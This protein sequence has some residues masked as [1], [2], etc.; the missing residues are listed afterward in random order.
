MASYLI[1]GGAGFI[2]SHLAELLLAH[3]DAV[4]LL[5]NMSTGQAANLQSGAELIRGDI[6][7]A[8]AVAQA[9]SRVDGV[10]HLAA[11]SSVHAYL[12]HWAASSSVNACG[13][14][15][16]FEAAARGGVP[17]VYASSA[18]VY[19][20]PAELPLR[21][22]APLRPISGY[23]TDKLGNELHASAMAEA[24]GLAAVGLR[25]F[26]V[27][28]PRQS[29][30]SAYSGVISIFMDRWR[31]RRSLTVFGDG[32]QT[33][34]FVFV[35][36]VAQALAAAM[37]RAQGGVGGVF[38]VCSGRSTSILDLVAALSQVVGGPLDFEFA[39]PRAGEISASLG[40][41]E[42]AARE[43][44][45]R[46]RTDFVAGLAETLAWAQLPP[47]APHIDAPTLARQEK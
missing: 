32:S 31:S 41:P 40:A 3:G 20:N 1:T 42:A 46:A 14:Y 45:F 19:G 12:G 9:L 27:Y 15:T 13:S 44:G 17:L 38:N 23:G 4:I 24:L 43:L 26:N 25:F 39:P 10:F 35:R 30:D 21:E 47:R 33:R 22:T 5:D 16:V 37:A 7:D 2:G 36:D 34:D 6:R 18:A 29:P 28:G 11:V 8:G